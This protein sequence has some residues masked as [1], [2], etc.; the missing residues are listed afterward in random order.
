MTIKTSVYDI[1]GLVAMCSSDDT[2]PKIVY[3]MD[4]QWLRSVPANQKPYLQNVF[5]SRLYQ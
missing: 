1:S 2:L 3:R 4:R 5:L